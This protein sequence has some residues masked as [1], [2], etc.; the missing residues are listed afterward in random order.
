MNQD[1]IHKMALSEGEYMLH[2]AKELLT[3]SIIHFPDDLPDKE[4]AWKDIVNLIHVR[5]PVY[6]NLDDSSISIALG[7]A[8]SPVLDKKKAWKDLINLTHDDKG[9]VRKDA[10]MA[11]ETA[12]EHIPNKEQAWQDLI[13]LHW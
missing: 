13:P 4:Q 5:D 11:L 9:F 1:K 3:S 10:A 7:L 2:T 6:P 8:F 12:F